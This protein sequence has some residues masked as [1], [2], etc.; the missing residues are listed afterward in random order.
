MP[1]SLDSSRRPLLD[2]PPAEPRLRRASRSKSG[3]GT[4][5]KGG[6]SPDD[7]VSTPEGEYNDADDPETS[8]ATLHPVEQMFAYTAAIEHYAKMLTAIA[9]EVGAVTQDYIT[10]LRQVVPQAAMA[11]MSGQ[12]LGLAPGAGAAM[13]A[14]AGATGQPSGLGTLAGGAAGVGG[15]GAM[16]GGQPMAPGG[17]AGG[18]YLM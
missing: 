14:G 1:S 11:R 5:A 7:D 8:S 9:P 13:S 3:L 10:L 6:N 15:G 12:P 2:E 18:G 16:G 17:G 4:L